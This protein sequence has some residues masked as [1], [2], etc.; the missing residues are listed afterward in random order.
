VTYDKNRFHVAL[1]RWAVAQW[2]AELEQDL[3][4]LRS[5]P[6]TSAR[7][8]VEVLDSL[9]NGDRCALATGLTKVFHPAAVVALSEPLTS[10]EEGMWSLWRSTLLTTPAVRKAGLERPQIDKRTLREGVRRGLEPVLGPIQEK[11]G[12][13]WRYKTV[14]PPFEVTTDLDFGGRSRQMGYFHSIR[15]P[16][17]P[18]PFCRTSL[19][20]WLG[21]GTE[22]R[23]THIEMGN[24]LQAA[25][26]VARLCEH[27]TKALQAGFAA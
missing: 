13:V 5:I 10:A 25:D 20:G 27:F 19:F 12:S 15:L 23:W 24:E 6:S 11:D 2:A 16:E 18:S 4:T 22:T 26:Q 1:Y 9:S 17:E 21:L 8:I 7:A 3:P 14:I